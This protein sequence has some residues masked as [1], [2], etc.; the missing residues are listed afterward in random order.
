M[1]D[2][3]TYIRL[4]RIGDIEATTKDE[5]LVEMCA[6]IEGAEAVPDCES[7]LNALR[8]RERIMSTGIGMG[9]A[10]PHT[11]LNSVSDFV[12]AIGRSRKGIDFESLD[13]LPVRVVVL[14][15]GPARKRTAF[16][17]LMASVGAVFNR[18]SFMERFLEAPTH[19]DMHRLI[20][21]G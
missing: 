14:M 5:A 21:E 18:P 15:A 3:S 6:M 7:F 13:G 2:L 9:V 12:V 16:L 20:L 8:E 1:A 11:K 19:G 4:D 17:H 10:V